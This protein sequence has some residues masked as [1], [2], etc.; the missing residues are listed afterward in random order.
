MK[1]TLLAALVVATVGLCIWM[2]PR[3]KDVPQP[4]E[5]ANIPSAKEKESPVML[6]A[7]GGTIS[8]TRKPGMDQE[9][10]FT[11]PAT[12]ATVSDAQ[13]AEHVPM[14]FSPGQDAQPVPAQRMTAP[15][16]TNVVQTPAIRAQAR[17]AAME[18]M[19]RTLKRQRTADGK[20]E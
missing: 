10:P 8:V 20:A 14:T 9:S 3:N 2:F 19:L 7:G 13:A 11:G 12:P 15:P 17:T 1:K 18:E 6:Q 5:T 4:A 16:F